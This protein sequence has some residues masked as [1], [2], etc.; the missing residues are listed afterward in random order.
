MTDAT[1]SDPALDPEVARE[2]RLTGVRL[3]SHRLTT[4]WQ[5]ARQGAGFVVKHF[6]PESL[7][8]WPYVLRVA[9]ALR[10]QGWP[11]PE[12]VEAPLV[13]TDGAWVMFHELPGQPKQP[14]AGDKPA[15]Q[16]A[17]GRLLAEFH[18][19]AVATGITDQRAG[20]TGPEALVADPE[21]ERWL[22]VHEAV[23]PEEGR[24]L[25]TYRDAAAQWF[26]CHPG[27]D[28][29][30]SVIHSDFAPWNL[31]FHNGRLTG[32][33]D[34]EATHHNFQVADFALSWRGYQDDVL[35]GYN[36]V[37]PLSAAEWEL[38][39]PVFWSWMFLGVKDALVS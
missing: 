26:A 8:D 36:D 28:A 7:P 4:T 35:R 39:R 32:V 38:L 3:L 17:R 11:T 25:R 18:Q 37:R 29:P 5:A 14:A 10:Q 19:A 13:R 1:R 12:P 27:L 6:G 21:L 15:E 9:A 33:L 2:W 30:S 16:I 22:R 24:I 23:N 31:L 20:F 34:F